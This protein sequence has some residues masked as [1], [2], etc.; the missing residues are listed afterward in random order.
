MKSVWQGTLG[1]GGRK[2]IEFE[3][4]I[5]L[6][7]HGTPYVMRRVGVELRE[8]PTPMIRGDYWLRVV[9]SLVQ[10]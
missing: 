10:K 9:V 1:I 8:V 2:A 7:E 3:A 4:D 5:M 6:D